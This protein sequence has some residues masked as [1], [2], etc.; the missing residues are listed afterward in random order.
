MYSISIAAV[1]SGGGWGWGRMDGGKESEWNNEDG[2][3]KKARF[4]HLVV[5]PGSTLGLNAGLN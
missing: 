5:T 2:R 1:K 3:K 4:Y